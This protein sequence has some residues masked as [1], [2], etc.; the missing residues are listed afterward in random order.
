MPTKRPDLSHAF[1]DLYAGCGGSIL[2]S[3]MAGWKCLAGVEWDLSACFTM[4]SNLALPGWT[5]FKIDPSLQA[6]ATKWMEKH[7]YD[8]ASQVQYSHIPEADWITREEEISPI[9]SIWCISMLDLEPEELMEV[10]D[11]RPGELGLISGGPPCQGFSYA[12]ERNMEDPRNQHPFRFLY[13]IKR[14]QPKLFKMENVPGLMTLGRKKHEKYGPF[15]HWI[16]NAAKEA[17]Y[18]IE[19]ETHNAADYGVPQNRK[20]VFFTG[21]RNDIYESGRRHG[22]DG[23]RLPGS[24]GWR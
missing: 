3:M 14:I 17:G 19:W 22:E 15:V 21:I 12:G 10:L 7:N 13:F 9:L 16:V 4:W 18:H 23:P 2:G 8:T 11:I 24:F 6:K 20:R 5:H 1:I